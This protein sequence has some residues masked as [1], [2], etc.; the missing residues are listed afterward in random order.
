MSGILTEQVFHQLP[1]Y[2]FPLAT[3]SDANSHEV[4]AQWH[5]DMVLPLQFPL[6]LNVLFA[7]VL[8]QECRIADDSLRVPLCRN[9]NSVNVRLPKS[10]DDHA[11]ISMFVEGVT[12]D[13]TKCSEVLGLVFLRFFDDLDVK[14]PLKCVQTLD[15]VMATHA[16]LL[17]FL[18]CRSLLVHGN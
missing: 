13:L 16:G 3:R 17:F 15:R 9:N 1:T 14:L 5:L 11:R 6:F 18:L 2:A 8:N 10:L 4:G 12:I 7:R